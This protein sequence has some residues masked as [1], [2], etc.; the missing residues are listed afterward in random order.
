[1]EPH[2]HHFISNADKNYIKPSIGFSTIFGDN[3]IRIAY[4]ED[5]HPLSQASLSIEDTAGIPT[6]FEF[7]NPGGRITQGSLRL[8]RNFGKEY[9]F[10][11]LSRQF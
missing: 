1:M 3:T 5:Y 7:M 9:S 8:S 10:I 6:R 2:K 4:I 11:C